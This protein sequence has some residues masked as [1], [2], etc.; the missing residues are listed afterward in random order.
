MK[1]YYIGELEQ[2]QI[3]EGLAFRYADFSWNWENCKEN[4][5]D[6]RHKVGADE[7]RKCIHSLLQEARKK[8]IDERV[9]RVVKEKC[10]D[11]RAYRQKYLSELLKEGGVYL[12]KADYDKDSNTTPKHLP[13]QRVS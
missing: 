8:N 1:R 3:I 6:E 13:M 12:F 5:Y 7:D 11:W 9:L 4:P 2:R 10:N